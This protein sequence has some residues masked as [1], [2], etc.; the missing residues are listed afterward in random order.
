MIFV[1][2]EDG[3][4][5]VVGDLKEAQRKYPGIDVESGVFV[6]Y[7]ENGN[8]LQPHFIVPN[9]QKSIFGL[10]KRYESGVFELKA[11]SETSEDPIWLALYETHGLNENR[12]FKTLDEVKSFFTSKG[13]N[14]GRP[15]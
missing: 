8:Y 13:I 12:F 4:L 2:I 1:F 9:K 3:R 11:N 6:F 15:T 7:D 14:T 5:D 10:F